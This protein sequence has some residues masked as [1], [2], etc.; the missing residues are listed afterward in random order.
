MRY[1]EISM[2]P[3]GDSGQFIPDVPAAL[4]RQVAR[5]GRAMARLRTA[6]KRLE[7]QPGVSEPLR[8]LAAA[9]LASAASSDSA[10]ERLARVIAGAPEHPAAQEMVLAVMRVVDGVECGA[11][12]VEQA[13]IAAGIP[14]PVR[15]VEARVESP[16][17]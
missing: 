2:E 1:L 9:G 6:Q 11:E 8:K 10:I 14:A 12:V 4:E 15:G 17:T 5:A 13:G 3:L 7:E 16:A